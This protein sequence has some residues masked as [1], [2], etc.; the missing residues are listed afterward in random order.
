MFLLAFSCSCNA[1][2]S[3]VGESSV[4]SSY[5]IYQVCNA[6][7]P[8]IYWQM[9]LKNLRP[10]RTHVPNRN[11][12]NRQFT[13]SDTEFFTVGIKDSL[14]LR[15]K[16]REVLSFFI[17]NSRPYCY[18]TTTTFHFVLLLHGSVPNSFLW[19]CFIST[20][21]P[22]IWSIGIGFWLKLGTDKEVG[23]KVVGTRIEIG[24]STIGITWNVPTLMSTSR[25]LILPSCIAFAKCLPI[26]AKYYPHFLPFSDWFC[27]FVC[28]LPN[29]PNICQTS[30]Q[31]FASSTNCTC[32]HNS[33]LL[34]THNAAI[35]ITVCW[36]TTQK[37][38]LYC[39]HLLLV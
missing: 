26:C 35:Y 38:V 19:F 31:M 39:I 10:K 23:C 15:N 20:I 9:S 3:T 16:S 28:F 4:L 24:T 18:Q 37:P 6:L 25:M 7:V 13:I 32:Q 34:S 33:Y 21:I 27:H 14:I 12:P 17:H 30:C 36:Y 22:R 29:K 8:V 5:S 2:R 11:D 1:Q